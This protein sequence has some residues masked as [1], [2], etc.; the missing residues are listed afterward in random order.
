[1]VW[2]ANDG[3]AANGTFSAWSRDGNTSIKA[4]GTWE[5]VPD[6]K[7]C[8]SASWQAD[9]K[10]AGAPE[11]PVVKTCFSHKVKG[12]EIAQRKDPDGDWY[13]FKHSKA[14]RG[15]EIM[16]LRNG[17]LALKAN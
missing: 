11:A 6:G 5:A 12:R 10:P 15:D 13:I 7:L 16:K 3:F 4:D 14:Q 1:M 9:P 8:F 2:S 17:K